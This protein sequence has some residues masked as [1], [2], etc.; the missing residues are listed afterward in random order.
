M[1][2]T[3][4]L[5]KALNKLDSQERKRIEASIAM[6]AKAW[7]DPHR[8]SGISIRGIRPGIYEARC[9][10]RLR[11]LFVHDHDELVFFLF[12]DHDA[13]QKWIRNF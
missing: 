5:Q 3:G 11:L 13:V 1:R 4:P 6:V 8:H 7:G 9:G 2:Y 12:G 10:L